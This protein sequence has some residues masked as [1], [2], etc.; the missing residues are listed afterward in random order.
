MST[1]TSI[2]ELLSNDHIYWLHSSRRS[3]Y[4]NPFA[5]L[6]TVLEV[7]VKARLEGKEDSTIAT[8][9]FFLAGSVFNKTH[10]LFKTENCPLGL[11]FPYWWNPSVLWVNKIH[12]RFL[13]GTNTDKT[14]N[15]H[16]T[17]LQSMGRQFPGNSQIFSATTTASFFTVHAIQSENSLWTEE[18][19]ILPPCNVYDCNGLEVTVAGLVSISG[20]WGE[21]LTLIPP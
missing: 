4:W 5:N 12:K 18:Y 19:K 11:G 10:F 1:L 3:H 7:Y 21:G 15:G 17:L 9:N 2:S 20:A 13:C 6:S 14:P 16:I 8:S